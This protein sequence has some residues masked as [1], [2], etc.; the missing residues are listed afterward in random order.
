MSLKDTL[1][2]IMNHP[3]NQDDKINALIRFIRWQVGARIYDKPVIHPFAEKSKL[4]VWKGLTGATGNLYCGLHEFHDMGFMLHLLRKEDLFIDVGANIGSYSI[5]AAS[6]V[7]AKTISIEPVPKTYKHLL[8]NIKINDVEGLV[9]ALNIGL[10]GEEGTLDFTSAFD[11][12]NHVAK[13]GDENTI[14]VK[15]DT[16]D[17]VVSNRKPILAKID[18]EGYETNVLEGMTSTLT[19][20]TLKAVIIELNGSGMRYGYREDEIEKKF[21]SYGFQPYTYDPFSRELV[22]LDQRGDNNTLFIRDLAFVVDRL[23]TA[24]SIKVFNKE[25]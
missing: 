19:D 12:V 21:R 9:V 4:I 20:S 14:R 11:T 2:Y 24:R 7:G 6:E 23:R 25:F 1:K 16:F 15:V 17:K 13:D 18:V 3:L 5:L 10:S 8:D 22:K